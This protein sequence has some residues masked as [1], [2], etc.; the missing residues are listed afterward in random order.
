MTW[1]TVRIELR[2]VA[3]L[4]EK[5]EGVVIAV[6]GELVVSGGQS[7]QALSRNRREVAGELGVL[8]QDHYASGHEAVYERFLTHW[9]ALSHHLGSGRERE[10][11]E[12]DN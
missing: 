4:D 1:K 11:E 10:R 8:G 2:T 6:V 12:R 3:I 5:I 7:L 9:P